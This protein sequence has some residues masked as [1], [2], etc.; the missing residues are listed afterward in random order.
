[1][2]KKG[3]KFNAFHFPHSPQKKTIKKQIF[4]DD[5]ELNIGAML[6]SYSENENE[7]KF[8]SQHPDVF[9]SKQATWLVRLIDVESRETRFFSLRKKKKENIFIIQCFQWCQSF[10][11][12]LFISS[13]CFFFLLS[14]YRW[15]IFFLMVLSSK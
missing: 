8:L 3:R 1:M 2:E 6:K 12:L 9:L 14:K 11:E 10:A 13:L 5:N 15:K 7:K 4:Y